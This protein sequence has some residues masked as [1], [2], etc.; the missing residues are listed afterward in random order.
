[1]APVNSTG[2][3]NLTSDDY[4]RNL[5][6]ATD[7]NATSKRMKKE[8]DLQTMDWMKLLVA[9]LKNQDMYNQT[10]SSEMTAQMAQYSQIQA[11]QN[12]VA[13]QEN[14]FAM[15][16][17][18]YAASLI[19][20]EV[21]VAEIKTVAT[22]GGNKDE[23]VKTKG[24]VTGVTLFEGKPHIYI[25]NK[26]FSLNQIMIVGEVPENNGAKEPEKAKD[27]K[28]KKEGEK[29]PAEGTTNP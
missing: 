13:M 23:V 1:M 10:D 25:G 27:D 18:S 26:K 16:N 4:I 8:L 6:K 28:D 20:K 12:M 29:K 21:T 14:I 2:T 9:Q 22:T 15:N 7:K 24:K 11:V 5:L 17:T 3:T 19:G